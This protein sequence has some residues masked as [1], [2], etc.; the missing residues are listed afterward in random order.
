MQERLIKN[1]HAKFVDDLTIAEAINLRNVL[2]VEP[3]DRLERPLNYHQRTEQTLKEDSSQVEHQLEK[4]HQYAITNEMKINQQKTKIMLFNTSTTNDFQPEMKID[5][6]K[7]E[8]VEQMKLL[9]VII[10]ND[11][12]WHENTNFISKK[13]FG[14]LWLLRRLKNMGASQTILLDIYNKQIRS[15]LEFGSVVWNSGLTQDNVTQIERVQKS[16]FGVILGSHYN[17]CEEACE[18][19]KMK[20]LSERRKLLS[21]KFAVKAS[22][23]PVHKTWFVQNQEESK[24]RVDKP[25]YKPVCARTERFLKS[26]I[27]YLTDLLNESQ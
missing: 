25:K 1:M 11:L 12:K 15:V 3:E 6:I 17:T 23:H 16:A 2:N 20:T 24:T 13:A 18:K 26:A 9:G 5:G 14:R 8:V 10:S 7:I 22:K 19:L 21:I 4:V 27:P